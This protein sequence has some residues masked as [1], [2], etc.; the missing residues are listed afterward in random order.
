[1]PNKTMIDV[2]TNYDQ[3]GLIPQEEDLDINLQ[4]Y[5][6]KKSSVRADDLM[7]DKYKSAQVTVLTVGFDLYKVA[8]ARAQHDILN[9]LQS[10]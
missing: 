6:S 8:I 5:Y 1:M 7:N 3:L 2:D 10:L 9:S 4:F